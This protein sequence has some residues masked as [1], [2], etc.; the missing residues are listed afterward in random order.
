MLKSAVESKKVDEK[1]LKQL[2]KAKTLFKKII[3]KW[4]EAKSC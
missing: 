2:L 4:L 3:F 1:P